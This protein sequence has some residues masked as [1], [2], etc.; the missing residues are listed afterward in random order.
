MPS[1]IRFLYAAS[2]SLLLNMM[3]TILSTSRFHLVATFFQNRSRISNSKITH[4]QNF[5]FWHPT[6]RNQTF[7]SFFHEKSSWDALVRSFDHNT[8]DIKN[9]GCYLMKRYPRDI[10]QHEIWSSTS[11][12]IG[13][14][15]RSIQ[16]APRIYFGSKS[17]NSKACRITCIE[18]VRNQDS[19]EVRKS[20]VLL[21]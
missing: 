14:S 21:F 15:P 1:Q 16:W 5:K 4:E 3:S 2:A 17:E 8:C 7:H 9:I 19:C 6:G 11:S 20:G 12:E 18:V 10:E 13:R